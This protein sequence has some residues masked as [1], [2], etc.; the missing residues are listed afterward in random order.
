MI[1]NS[2]KKLQQP[3]PCNGAPWRAH[4]GIF[5]ALTTVPDHPSA[6]GR[7]HPSPQPLKYLYAWSGMKTPTRDAPS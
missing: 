6:Q 1:A 4:Y 2:D 3:P 7:F 5:H